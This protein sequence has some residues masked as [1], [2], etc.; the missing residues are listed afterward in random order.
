[1]NLQ[2]KIS[3]IAI[4]EI[5][6]KTFWVTQQYLEVMQV[7]H[8]DNLP[9]IRHININPEWDYATIYFSIVNEPFFLAIWVN[10]QPDLLLVSWVWIESCNEIY[11]DVRS[12]EFSSS[13]LKQLTNLTP[14]EELNKGDSHPNWK[15]Q[16]KFSRIKFYASKNPGSFDEKIDELLSFLEKD[17]IWIKNLNT[18][19]DAS[20]V[21]YIR[22]YYWNSMLGW[23]SLDREIISRM[24]ALWLW[25]DYDLYISGIPFND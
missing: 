8:Q 24:N 4:N 17:T 10:V 20:I 2:D 7:E 18:K 9:K 3:L 25:I 22:M 16:Y 5:N 13:E 21:W 1:M 14:L 15:I 12:S 19:A 6:N 11:L 23:P